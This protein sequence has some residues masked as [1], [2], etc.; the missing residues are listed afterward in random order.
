MRIF[1]VILLIAIAGVFWFFLPG[2]GLSDDPLTESPASLP[3]EN[4]IIQ[5]AGLNKAEAEAAVEDAIRAADR[6][7]VAL[8]EAN[9][10]LRASDA[11]ATEGSGKDVEDVISRIR[12]AAASGNFN[13]NDVD[14]VIGIET[15]SR[16]QKATLKRL[17]ETAGSNP[18]LLDLALTQ[19]ILAMR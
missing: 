17:V 12:V 6:P 19:A 2:F 13:Q 7:E 10:S 16:M 11:T 14:K 9:E 18:A 5:P 8:T 15:V 3:A 1:L 4:A